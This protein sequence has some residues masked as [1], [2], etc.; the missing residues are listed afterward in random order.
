MD[1]F[2]L[3]AKAKVL[4]DTCQTPK[5]DWGSLG[6]GTQDQWRAKVE[7]GMTRGHYLPPSHKDYVQWTHPSLQSS[8]LPALS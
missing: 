4:Y 5:P 2:A 6:E 7:R 8:V 1:P 3:T